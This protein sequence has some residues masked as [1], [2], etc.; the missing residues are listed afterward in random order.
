MNWKVGGKVRGR[1]DL[2]NCRT[3]QHIKDKFESSYEICLDGPSGVYLM[4]SEPYDG[5]CKVGISNDP[6]SRLVGVKRQWKVSSLKV[7]AYL[8][9]CCRRHAY[10][11]EKEL[12]Q[13]LADLPHYD[14]SCRLTRTQL[15]ESEWFILSHSEVLNFM[16]RF[17]EAS[18]IPMFRLKDA[19]CPRLYCPDAKWIYGVLSAL[20]C[21]PP[22][23]SPLSIPVPALSGSRLSYV[24]FH[25][26]AN[27]VLDAFDP[28][29][30]SGHL[31]SSEEIER[32]C[33]A[34]EILAEELSLLLGNEI[35]LLPRAGED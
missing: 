12:H 19:H 24:E 7:V 13:L 14:S 16:A 8:V 28:Y 6:T 21:R 27:R 20:G 31:Y 33:R 32:N 4:H 5:R 3:E 1:S 26:L 15:G 18:K 25:R 29:I 2:K 10:V 34:K 30:G 11:I 9:C 22:I 23:I 17:A 35:G